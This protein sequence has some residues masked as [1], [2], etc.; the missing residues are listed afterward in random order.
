MNDEKVKDV[1]DSFSMAT[2]KDAYVLFYRQKDSSYFSSSSGSGSTPSSLSSKYSSRLWSVGVASQPGTPTPHHTTPP[3]L[4]T[5]AHQA[6]THSPHSQTELAVIAPE[7]ETGQ[8]RN[9]RKAPTFSRADS[10]PLKG[11]SSASAQLPSFVFSAF[12]V[13]R[14]ASPPILHA[15]TPTNSHRF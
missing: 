7:N 4:N 1:T 5:H 9:S 6:H 2:L 3:L 8:S 15:T 13:L 12:S 10:H 11:P 14:R